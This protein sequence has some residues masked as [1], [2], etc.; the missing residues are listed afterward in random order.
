M[1]KIKLIATSDVHGYVVPY[2]YSDN[3]ERL[4][5][6]SRLAPIINE[7]RDENTLLL[8]NG[9]TIQGSPQLYYQHISAPDSINPMSICLNYLKYDYVNT[10]NHEFN[11]GFDNMLKYYD[12]LDAKW[13]CGNIVYKNEVM[14]KP[15]V[16]HQ[17]KN[18]VR[19]ALIGA[20]TDYIPNWEQPKNIKDVSFNNT[21]NFIKAS[22]ETIK[23]HETVDFIVVMYHGGFERDLVSGEVTEEQ[24]GE[25][26]GYRICNEIDGIDVLISGHQHRS[27]AGKCKN[28]VVS[29]SAFNGKELAVIELDSTNKEISVRLVGAGADYD[30]KLLEKIKSYE[31]ATQIWLDQPMGHLASGDLL[32][33]DMFE[34]RLHKHPMVSFLNQVQLWA[35]N[36]QISGVALANEVSG[37]NNQITMRDIVSTYVFPNTLAVI[38][39]SGRDVILTI[40]RCA[41][42]FALVD[43]KIGITKRFLEPK[44]AHYNYDMFDGISY[45]IDVRKPM[46]QRVSDVTIEGKPIELDTMYTMVVN[47]YR[48]AGGG[49]FEMMKRN[50]IIKEIQIDVVECIAN[51]IQEHQVIHVD[52]HDNIKVIY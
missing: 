5:G 17:F 25:N 45:T 9:D 16:I 26:V 43:G 42:Y 33:K 22:V 7:L 52:H 6:L 47:N 32:I 3:K 28:V 8:D 50:K 34:A 38:E 48:A 35:S 19:L 12:E 21:F 23:K 4:Q 15:Y 40:E 20:V 44:P 39:M 18:G 10:G 36:A 13:I 30:E 27:I 2:A 49:N 31:D 11:Y 29:Q 24:T 46:G 41:E 1:S 14:N 51:Y 37:F